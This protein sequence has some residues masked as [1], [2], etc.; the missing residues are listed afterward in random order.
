MYFIVAFEAEI[1]ANEDRVKQALD[2]G[3]NLIDNKKCAGNEGAVK[4][5]LQY[6]TEQWNVLIEKTKE[7]TVKLKE[8]NK[9]RDFNAAV[10]DLDFW[11]SENESLLKTDE[12]GKDLASVQALTK[13]HQNLEAD[14]TAREERIK[15]M[16]ALADSL[17][18]SDQLDIPVLQEKRNSVNERYERVKTLS[19]YRRDRLGE[20]NT[21]HCF[22]RDIADQ[23]SWIREKKLLLDSA[24]F[25]K[26][27]TGVN[28]LRKKHKRFEGDIRAHE[29]AIRAVQEMGQ[30]LMAETN[31]NAPEIEQRLQNL[32]TNWQDLK[33]LSEARKDRLEESL[34]YQQFLA[35]LEEEES[36][37]AEKMKL[38]S[39]ENYGDSIAAVQGLLKKNALFDGDYQMHKE[40]YNDF[41][42]T[43]DGLVAEGNH[44]A[45]QIQEKLKQLL[46]NL[47]QL[48]QLA[49]EKNQRLVDNYDYLQ[50]L[51]KADVVE[52]WIAEKEAQAQAED[53][54]RDLPS[55]SSL[56]SVSTSLLLSYLHLYSLALL[57]FLSRNKIT[58]KVA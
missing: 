28:N 40:R 4:E 52:S 49:E 54:G 50:F 30:K 5:R 22:F 37:V 20:G 44:Y 56:L 25:G 42:F 47:E 23:E 39:D 26:D 58:S 2:M 45:P 12:T 27:L 32:E 17:I 15:D 10:K 7:K 41:V 55:V 53:L 43:G 16:N 19:T 24:D 35:N 46:K 9:R 14:I 33:S 34:I 3:E 36:W 29:P 38:L 48:A 57:Y 11:L 6:I 21:L 31:S 13:K 51:W 18:E 1:N 8:A